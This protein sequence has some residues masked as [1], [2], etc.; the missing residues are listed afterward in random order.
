MC[1]KEKIK[2]F[3]EDYTQLHPQV[4]DNYEAW[5]FGDNP[6]MADELLDLVIRG[7]KTGTASNYEVYEVSE[8]TLPEIGR[9]SILLDGHGNP[10]AVIVTTNVQI[11]PFD[12]VSADFAYT[13]GEDDRTLE[14][15]RHEHEKFF[16]RESLAFLKKPF[17]PKMKVV[18]EN[19]KLEYT[20]S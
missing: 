20:K 8:E 10:Q 1:N 2:L 7:I 18:C 16:T 15:W 12:E 4:A 3:W 14:S 5:A 9:H 6:Q 11:T 19:F 17:K 13:E